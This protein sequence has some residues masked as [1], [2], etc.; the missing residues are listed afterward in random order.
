MQQH[1]RDPAAVGADG[2]PVERA[3]G[4]LP[5]V[6]AGGDEGEGLV[7]RVRHFEE[8]WRLSFEDGLDIFDQHE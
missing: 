1:R 5:E 3:G 2:V 4:G 6:R 7:E 8:R